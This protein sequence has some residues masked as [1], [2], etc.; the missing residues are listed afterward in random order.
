[1]SQFTFPYRVDRDTPAVAIEVQG[2]FDALLTWIE[3]NCHRIDDTPRMTAQLVL[4]GNPTIDS[5]AV[6]KSYVDGLIPPGVM[7]DFAGAAAPAGWLLCDGATYT[8]TQYPELFA[9]IGRAF[10][11]AAVPTGSFQVP[12]FQGRSPVGASATLARGSKI[13]SENVTAHTHPVAAHRHPIAHGHTASSGTESAD[14][15]HDFT[16]TGNAGFDIVERTP[17][18][19]TTGIPLTDAG[20]KTQIL[21]GAPIA[22]SV[23]SHIHAIAVGIATAWRSNPLWTVGGRTVGRSAAH[24]HAIT[25]NASAD[26]SGD[27]TSTATSTGDANANRPPSLVTTKIIKV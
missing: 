18:Y 24:S 21:T 6:P 26:Q 11:D 16:G 7:W 4:P 13:G 12:D 15:T 27:G 20:N 22:S 10:T 25:V 8:E 17:N 23:T 3:Q 14:H 19:D 9:I 2:N 5:H 1:M